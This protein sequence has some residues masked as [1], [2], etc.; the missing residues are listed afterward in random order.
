MHVLDIH[1]R[2][3]VFGFIERQGHRS[4]D[5]SGYAHECAGREGGGVEEF[6]LDGDKT[7][8]R[9]AQIEYRFEG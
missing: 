4:G 3:G 6:S 8:L 2:V 5:F 9:L 1:D 7:A